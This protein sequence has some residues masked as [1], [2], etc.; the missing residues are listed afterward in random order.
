MITKMKA[1][2]LVTMLFAMFLGSAAWADFIPGT[3]GDPDIDVGNPDTYIDHTS[4][5]TEGGS[6]ACPGGNGSN[7]TAEECWAE[8]ASG[9]DLTF[10]DSKTE[11]VDW[12]W[13]NDGNIAFELAYG[14]GYYILKNGI[15]GGSSIWV[16]FQNVASLDWGVIAPAWEDTANLGSDMIISHVTELNGGGDREVPEPGSLGLLGAGL[17][18]LGLLRR[19]RRKKA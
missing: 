7:P 9:V 18:G 10:D 12:Y 15:G 5:L 3:G 16:L 2:K 11:S 13:T 8:D 17:I 19:T 1:G 14:G 4:D 6:I